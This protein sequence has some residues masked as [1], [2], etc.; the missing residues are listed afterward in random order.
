MASQLWSMSVA[1]VGHSPAVSNTNN[2]DTLLKYRYTFTSRYQDSSNDWLIGFQAKDKTMTLIEVMGTSYPVTSG[3]QLWQNIVTH[4]KQTMMEDL[5]AS[6][7]AWKASK[8]NAATILKSNWKPTFEWKEDRLILKGVPH[9]DVY[10]HDAQLNVQPL[11][12]VGIH[13][14]LAEKFGLLF[15]DK[16]NQYQLGPNLDFVLPTV[17]YNASTPPTRSNQRVSVVGRAFCR[18]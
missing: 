6:S 15:K 13:V 1:D 17:T 7:A 16:K 18:Y 10:A 5:N 12:S 2:D 3:I 8:N 14:D 4:M 11:S 9:E